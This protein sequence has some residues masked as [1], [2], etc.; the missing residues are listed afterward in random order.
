MLII[1]VPASK[2]TTPSPKTGMPNSTAAS[3]SNGTIEIGQSISPS[4]ATSHRPYTNFNTPSPHEPN[5][6]HTN[7]L[8]QSTAPSNNLLPPST[9]LHH[10]TKKGITCVQQ[11]TGTLLY[12]ARSVDPTMLPAIGTIAAQQAHGTE[13]TAAAVTHLL[14]YTATHP[15]A[16]IRYQASDMILKIHSTA[17]Y[18]SETQ[19]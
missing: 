17:S 6:P 5:T 4:R 3:P 7:G 14:D 15:N 9:S 16:T 11:I 12:Y 10:S 18:L 13:A 19:A 1:S 2:R 8:N